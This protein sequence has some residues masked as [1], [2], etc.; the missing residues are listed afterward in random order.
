[1]IKPPTVEQEDSD[2]TASR[3]I[4]RY[5]SHETLQTRKPDWRTKQNGLIARAWISR[6]RNDTGYH[7]RRRNVSFH[8]TSGHSALARGTL[9]IWKGEYTGD[10]YRDLQGFVYAGDTISNSAYEAALAVARIWGTD[11]D[12][13]WWTDEP[14]CYGDVCIFDRLVIAA[15]S[16]AAEVEAVWQAIEALVQRL[17]RGLAVVILKAFPLEYESRVTDENSV[18]FK[19]RQQALIRLYRRRL[20]MQPVP[21]PELSD[22]GWMMRLMKNGVGPEIDDKL[23]P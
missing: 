17:R 16:S 3:R 4:D 6:F 14:F 10:S 1:M 21:H 23:L 8:I 18:K 9:T 11:D 13:N 15:H 19:K 5:F 20:K 7:F 12:G 22:A 2:Q